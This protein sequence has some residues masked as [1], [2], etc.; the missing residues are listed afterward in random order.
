MRFADNH[1]IALQI[2][3]YDRHVAA[4]TEDFFNDLANLQITLV[5]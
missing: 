4:S 3:E 2:V 1:A 5:I